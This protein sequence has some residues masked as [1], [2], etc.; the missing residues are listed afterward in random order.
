METS[1][2]IKTTVKPV[3]KRPHKRVSKTWLAALAHE[4][5]GKIEDMKAV[6]K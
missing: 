4:G 6:L 5:T 3:T 1:K 2:K